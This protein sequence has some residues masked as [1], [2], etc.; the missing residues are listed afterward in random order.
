MRRTCR[1]GWSQTASPAKTDTQVPVPA[2]GVAA[3]GTVAAAGSATD[4]PRASATTTIRA[5][6]LR[7]TTTVSPPTTPGS[8]SGGPPLDDRA[9][10]HDHVEPGGPHP[11]GG[12]FVDDVELEPYGA[13]ADRH[14]LIGDVTGQRGVDEDVHHVDREGDV[15]ERGVGGLAVDVLRHRMDRHDPPALVLQEVGHLVSGARRVV[16][17]PDDGPGLVA[18]DPPDDVVLGPATALVR[19]GR[20]GRPREP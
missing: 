8:G 13:R 9:P 10:V 5:A 19:G 18:E 7:R 15:G 20:H 6:L 11:V 16:A 12:V 2:K 14:G 3:G 4:P 17:Q 1:A